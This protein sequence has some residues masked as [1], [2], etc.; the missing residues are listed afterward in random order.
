MDAASAAITDQHSSVSPSSGVASAAFGM[1]W[2]A[3]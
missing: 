2:S 1:K 3:K